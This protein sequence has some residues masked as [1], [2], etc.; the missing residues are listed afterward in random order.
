MELDLFQE[1][2]LRAGASGLDTWRELADS[3]P[4][5]PEDNSGEMPDIESVDGP[6]AGLYA[7]PGI[8]EGG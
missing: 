4:E 5:A 2:W 8:W 7:A 3:R 1:T 6:V